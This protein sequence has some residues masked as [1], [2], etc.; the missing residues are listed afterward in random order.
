MVGKRKLGRTGIEISELALGGGVVGGII[1][2]GD[3]NARQR[4]LALALDNGINWIDTAAGYGDGKSE[5]VVG[6]LLAD[7]PAEQR[8]HVATK[9]RVNIENP[10]DI[11]GQVEASLTASLERLR[12]S[13]VTLLQLHNQLGGA[14][15]SAGSRTLSLDDLEKPGGVLD[16]MELLKSQGLTRHIGITALGVPQTCLRVIAGGRID[17]AQ[18]YYNL[19]N[20][21]SGWPSAGQQATA[22]RSTTDF[23]GLIEACEANDVGIFAIRVFAAG[24]LATRERHGREIPLVPGADLAAEEVRAERVF[25]VLGSAHGSRA[26]A[27]LRFALAEPRIASV[28]LGLSEVAQLDEAIAAAALGGLGPNTVASLARLYANDFGG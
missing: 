7:L 10:R 3:D 21:S 20:P 24:V 25:D 22:S 4:M 26:Q 23:A 17:T 27:A 19:L 12:M 14:Q 16:A 2:Y 18:I 28:V 11:A 15:A 1:P 8:P 5:I 13:S 6:A 9:F